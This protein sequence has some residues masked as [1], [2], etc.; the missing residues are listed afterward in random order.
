MVQV[1]TGYVK[2]AKNNAT[3]KVSGKD[4]RKTLTTQR[5]EALWN[6]TVT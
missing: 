6:E 2:Y 5:K 3:K 4:S 1:K